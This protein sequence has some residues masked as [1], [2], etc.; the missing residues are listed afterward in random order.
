MIPITAVKE[1]FWYWSVTTL[2]LTAMFTADIPRYVSYLF[3]F[4]GMLEGFA[5]SE[6]IRHGGE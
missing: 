3:C 6:R 5:A 1:F 2:V 4:Y